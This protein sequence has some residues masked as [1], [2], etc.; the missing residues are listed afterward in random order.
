PIDDPSVRKLASL[1][2]QR[3][4]KYYEVEGANDRVIVSLPLRSYLPAFQVVEA[5]EADE[6]PAAAAEEEPPVVAAAPPRPQRLW[7][8]LVALVLGGAGGFALHRAIPARIPEGEFH[9]QTSRGEM[10]NQGAE[11]AP[12]AIQLGPELGE[13]DEV[14]VRMRFRP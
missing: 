10:S 6:E 14:V 2:R 12:D 13:H 9:L 1:L 8:A 11:L 3:L 7:I 5:A 4:Q